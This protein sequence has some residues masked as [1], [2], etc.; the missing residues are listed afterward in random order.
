MDG[1]TAARS[2]VRTLIRGSVT[3][4]SACLEA[5]VVARLNPD[6]EGS[7]QARCDQEG[8]FSLDCVACDPETVLRLDGPAVRTTDLRLRDVGLTRSDGGWSLAPVPLSPEGLLALSVNLDAATRSILDA[9]E[10]LPELTIT[11]QSTA[12]GRP[13]IASATVPWMHGE[14]RV[15][16]RLPTVDPVL[17]SWAVLMR[18]GGWGQVLSAIPTEWSLRTGR[19]HPMTLTLDAQSLA[20]GRVEDESGRLLVECDVFATAPDWSTDVRTDA[21][22]RFLLFPPPGAEPLDLLARHGTNFASR[23]TRALRGEPT[24]VRVDA[25]GAVVLR[26][27]GPD[28]APMT[29]CSVSRS[30]FRRLPLDEDRKLVASPAGLMVLKRRSLE[31]GWL[32]I[33]GSGFEGAVRIAERVNGGGDPLE[34]RVPNDLR[35]TLTVQV[36]TPRSVPLSVSVDEVDLGNL[37]GRPP[38]Q[39]SMVGTQGQVRWSFHPIASG[40]YHVVVRE[41]GRQERRSLNVPVLVDVVDSDREI[42]VDW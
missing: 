2:V 9:H 35:W 28:G 3:A 36:K 7:I 21:D 12:T 39:Y 4:P 27:I 17:V 34:I 41:V 6:A 33:A 42:V 15:D 14:E 30:S 32:Y 22:G 25:R 37:D 5:G 10:V 23:K 18:R 8:S 38:R 40:T 20:F 19:Y 26:V 24:L 16:L 29:R 1:S 31:P 13:R 11:V